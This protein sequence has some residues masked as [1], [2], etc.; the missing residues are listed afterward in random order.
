MKKLITVAL[1]GLVTIVGCGT[2]EEDKK[3]AEAQYH[4]ALAMHAKDN[5]INQKD[6]EFK[7]VKFDEYGT[8]IGCMR[9]KT[10]EFIDG[11]YVRFA[12][13]DDVLVFMGMTLCN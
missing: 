2:S 1:I 10:G 4:V 11:E 6:I 5:T 13:S 9:P 12:Y 3:I 7:N 8:F